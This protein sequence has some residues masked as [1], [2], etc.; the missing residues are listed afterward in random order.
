[1]QKA[2]ASLLPGSLHQQVLYGVEMDSIMHFCALSVPL[3]QGHK[4]P[5]H[6]ADLRL[7]MRLMRAGTTSQSTEA[8]A[9]PESR[10]DSRACCSLGS[11]LCALFLLP[12]CHLSS[13]VL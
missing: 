10:V 11:L 5:G 2:C 6:G 9:P 8:T 13:M 3:V 12:S 7:P 4:A 1:M